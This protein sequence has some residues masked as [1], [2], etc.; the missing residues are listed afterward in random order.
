MIKEFE[1]GFEIPMDKIDDYLSFIESKVKEWYKYTLI[2]IEHI[3]SDRRINFKIDYGGSIVEA[4][5]MGDRGPKL[6]LYYDPSLPYDYVLNILL[7]I[8]YFTNEFYSIVR[9][10]NLILV[11]VPGLPVLPVKALNLSKRILYNIFTGSLAMIFALSLFIGL[12][13]FMFMGFYAP[14]G[15]ILFQAVLFA[16]SPKL[17]SHVGDWNI[18]GDHGNVYIVSC[19]FPINVFHEITSRKWNEVLNI[20]EALYNESFHKGIVPSPLIVSQIMDKFGFPCSIDKIK[21]KHIS[22]YDLVYEVCSKFNIKVPKIVL[23][24]TIAPNAG[25]SGPTIGSTLLVVTSG[26]L[27]KLNEDEL[28]AVLGHELSHCIRRDPLA[29]F[30]ISNFEYILRL[31]ILLSF[32][33]WPLDLLY[34][35]F[36]LTLLFFVA[37]FFEARADL[38]S[39]LV[40]GSGDFLANALLKIAFP[41]AFI[42]RYKAYRI[43]SWLRW[44]PHPPV[45]FRV[46]RLGTLNPYENFRNPFFRSMKDCIRGF[47]SSF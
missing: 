8:Q 30:L 36:A 38:D 17:L 21:I 28:K 25:A 41:M 47:I 23:A 37:K 20:K 5:L 18:S 10:G 4:N 7:N 1:L 13:F 16:L 40:F 31:Y 15:I 35:L 43:R 29:L 3:I 27:Y 34:F 42:E 9:E 14:I 46:L 19:S 22:L 24:N 33:I 12:F 44:N 39:F 26:L 6:T 2:S 45:Y 11:F 32:F